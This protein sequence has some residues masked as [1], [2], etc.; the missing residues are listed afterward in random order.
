MS[1]LRLASVTNANAKDPAQLTPTRRLK[2][3]TE[4]FDNEHDDLPIYT[5]LKLIDELLCDLRH[6]LN[7]SPTQ[8]LTYSS[9]TKTALQRLYQA[10][11]NGEMPE[12]TLTWSR[13]FKKN[14]KHFKD[15]QKTK[16]RSKNYTVGDTIRMPHYD[17][18]GGFRV[19]SI[20]GVHLGGTYQE[21]T[22]HLKCLDVHDNEEIHVP[23][24]ILETHPEI[25]QI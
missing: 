17:T 15:K 6:K 23:C 20:E 4:S 9:V 8:M 22:Y 2:M 19:W 16:N 25:E 10:F 24:I 18:S 7:I 21:G 5:D 14:S 13:L 12:I 3:A 11:S 1:Y